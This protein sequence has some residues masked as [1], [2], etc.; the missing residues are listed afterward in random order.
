MSFPLPDY[1][2]VLFTN[3]PARQHGR[4]RQRQR[5]HGATHNQINSDILLTRAVLEVNGTCRKNEMHCTHGYMYMYF[6]KVLP[7]TNLA[8]GRNWRKTTEM[9]SGTAT[10]KHGL[11]KGVRG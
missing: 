4:A 8:A 11:I 5:G 9:K 1:K 3:R 7:I 2:P 6:A 10:Y